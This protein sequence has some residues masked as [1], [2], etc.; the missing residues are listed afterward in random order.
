MPRRGFR[1]SS[2]RGAKAKPRPPHPGRHAKKYAGLRGQGGARPGAGRK[3]GPVPWRAVQRAAES[4]APFEEIV[5]GLE[6]SVDALQDKD[7]QE[8]MRAIIDRGNFKFK[9]RLRR[10]IKKRGI[11]EGSVNSLALMARNTLE[12]DQALAQVQ[13]APDLTALGISRDIRSYWV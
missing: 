4:G 5:A 12:R 8:Q 6:I 10:A 7:I 2:T 1:S 9:L 11:D 13:A 3:P